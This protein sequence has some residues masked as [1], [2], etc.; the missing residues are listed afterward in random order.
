MKNKIF[1]K[2]LV[3]LIVT[4]ML[5]GNFSFAIET[6][7][8]AEENT[9]IKEYINEKDNITSEQNANTDSIK[10]EYEYDENTNQVIAKIV[11]KIKLKNTK[12]TWKL[13]E[14]GFIYT[15]T[16]S[17]NTKYSTQVENINGEVTN[18]EVNV[19]D[20]KKTEIQIKYEY[21]TNKTQVTV[22]IVSN[23][24]LKN[25]KPTWKLSDDK[26][27]YSK[28]FTGN[29]QYTTPVE[30]IGGNTLTA[31]INVN[32]IQTPKANV[33]TKNTYNETTNKVV[34]QIISDVK[35]KNTK[36]TW[37]LSSDG[38]TY[39]KTYAENTDYTTS[40]EDIYGNIINVQIK[41]TEIKTTQLKVEN[42]YDDE[43]NTTTV[44]I[45]SNIKLKNTKPTWQL[46][47]DGLIYTKVFTDNM[48]YSTSVEDIFGNVI[49]VSIKV[50]EIDKEAP[51][52][53]VEYIYNKDDTLTAKIKSNKKLKD[54]KPTWELSSDGLVYTKTFTTDQNYSTAV[55]DY[56]GNSANAKI[57]FKIRKF[58]YNQDDNSTIKVRYLYIGKTQA[59]VEIISSIKL[60]NTKP[61][62]N[63]S[64]DGY[65][66]SKTFYSNQ[67]YGTTVV[68]IND[69]SKNVNVIVNLFDNYLTGIDVSSHQGRIN[70]SEVKNAGIDFAIIRCGYGQDITSQDDYMFVRNVLDCERLGIPY[71]VYLYSYALTE[72]DAYS[73]ASH[74]LRLIKG[75]NPTLGVWIDI[76]DADGYKQKYGMPSNETLTNIASIF[77]DKLIENGYKTGVYASYS[78]LVNQLSSPKLDKYDKWVAQWNDSCSYD[79][80]Y[81]M[82][83]YT[84]KGNV[85][86]VLTDV[87]MDIYYR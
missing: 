81:I 34:V 49:N 86:G 61:T 70:W 2:T 50:V 78:W 22:K 55:Q 14:D 28:V 21:N 65:T 85:T 36:P 42:K 18:V 27:T 58:I 37:Q 43:T 87:D 71:G 54:T 8:N 17:E 46:S 56:H 32:G 40:V 45:I 6:V 57:N 67:I 53:T 84:S 19:V 60:K 16:F 59:T 39:T 20:V 9:E 12:P 5:F 33:S 48:N 13:S 83:Q 79:K 68:D 47:S 82:W 4:I 80:K 75:H 3:I 44:N 63:L 73:E 41:V 15:K 24:K 35:F 52:I 29:T 69:V 23:V 1:F 76:E 72:S 25:T 64:E 77:C 10:V 66:Y 26:F 7:V 11:S 31:K 62:W 74:A 51:E 38:L 30:D